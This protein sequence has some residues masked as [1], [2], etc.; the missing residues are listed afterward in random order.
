VNTLRLIIGLVI[1]FVVAAI[2]V[3]NMHPEN[4]VMIR[5]ASGEARTTAGMLLLISWAAGV[6]SYAIF[7]LLGEVRLRT[8]LARQKRET[9]LLMRELNDLRNL[10]VNTED[11]GRPEG[12][13]EEKR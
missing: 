4:D 1:L 11:E 10:P 3:F 6:V 9:E 7:A 8:R 13:R 2:A 5:L 12:A